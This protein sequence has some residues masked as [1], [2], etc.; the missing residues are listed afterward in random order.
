[1]CNARMTFNLLIVL[2][3]SQFASYISSF[4]ITGNQCQ[5]DSHLQHR[6]PLEKEYFSVCR[7]EMRETSSSGLS[8]WP[9]VLFASF[10]LHFVLGSSSPT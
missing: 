3:G 7:N 6:R 1:M 8:W 5:V 2:M 4:I 9:M 10:V